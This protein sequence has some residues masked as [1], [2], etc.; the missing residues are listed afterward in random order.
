M[1]NTITIGSQEFELAAVEVKKNVR[2]KNPDKP[3]K[4]KQ[5]EQG[6]IVIMPV[7]NDRHDLA[8]L[9][10]A[11]LD[12]SEAQGVGN[13]LKLGLKLVLPHLEDASDAG[14]NQETGSEDVAKYKLTLASPTR[15]R[16]AGETLDS[17]NQQL[18]IAGPE[19]AVLSE[20]RFT[21]DGW[22]KLVNQETGAPLFASQD[23]YLLRYME[24][25]KE[26]NYLATLLSAKQKALAEM[27]AKR[28]DK[29]A[30]AKAKAI[31]AA[32][33]TANTVVIPKAI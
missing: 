5:E 20:V 6:V 18:A 9:F 19:L 2:V 28:E 26:I 31:E 12:E 21:A 17:I 24:V 15:P 3:G 33:D 8:R 16:S 29:A 23:Q 4:Y 27:K 7:V 30:A 1:S 11:M 13:G 32:T 25:L 14:F 10:G 22:K